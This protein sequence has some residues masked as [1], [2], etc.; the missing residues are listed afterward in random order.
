MIVRR[1]F[2]LLLLVCLGCSAQ[3][4]PAPNPASPSAPPSDMTRSIERHVRAQ[5]TLPTR[6]KC[7]CGRP[8]RASEFANYDALTVTFSSPTR[9]QDF[10]FLLSHDHKT[11]MRLSQVRSD[12]RSLRGD[13]EED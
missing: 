6:R 11:L 9:K 1:A 2:L 4:G 8:L 12:R 3:S 7:D 10:E 13:D 5:Y